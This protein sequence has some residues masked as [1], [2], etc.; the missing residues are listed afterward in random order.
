MRTFRS[1]IPS[2]VHQSLKSLLWT[3]AVLATVSSTAN[4]QNTDDVR[5]QLQDLKKQY[6][7]TTLEFQKRIADLEEK[8]DKQNP[9]NPE[10]ASKPKAPESPTTTTPPSSVTSSTSA[11]T[12]AT[13]ATTA[14]TLP[15]NNSILN[16]NTSSHTQHRGADSQAS[17]PRR[18]G[19]G[20]TEVSGRRPLRANLRSLERS[21]YQNQKTHRTSQQLRVPR[22]RPFGCG[23]KR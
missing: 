18:H 5:Q 8:I 14:S 22:L 3:M 21:R 23:R 11:S 12:S 4:A 19:A 1:F 2:S 9:P 20:R 7:Q 10:Q 13:A 6:E 16:A 15:A 17:L